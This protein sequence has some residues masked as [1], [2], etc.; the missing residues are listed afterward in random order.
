MGTLL[1]CP[2]CTLSRCALPHL[3]HAATHA[4]HATAHASSHGVHGRGRRVWL[5]CIHHRR[6][7]GGHEGSHGGRIHQRRAHHLCRVHHTIRHQ[8]RILVREGVEA[9]RPLRVLQH[10]AGDHLTC[11]AS[12][13][14]DGD[15][16]LAQSTLDELDAH[17]LV[18]VVRAG[19]Q[20]IQ[21]LRGTQERGS[22]TRHD[23]LLH[24]SAG[25]VQCVRDAV[26]LLAD[27]HLR[28]AT[29]LD[30]SDTAR[31]LGE[32]LAQ[33]L[34]LVLARRLLHLRAD[35][36]AALLDGVLAAC[37]VQHQGI[38]LG[39]GD[40]A[41][42]A[43]VVQCR[44]LQLHPH[45]LGDHHATRQLGDVLQV[46]LAV[47]TEAGGLDGAHLDLCPQAV[48][49]Q[50]GQ[51]LALNVLC[52]D[53]QRLVLADGGFQDVDDGL[54][55]RHL[56]L[57]QQDVR[58]LELHL[59]C[60]GVGDEVRRDEA[61]VEAHAFHDLQLVLQRPAVLHGDHALLA[62][63]LH[64]L[65]DEAANV[66]V[67]VCG[68]GGHLGDLFRGGDGGGFGGQ[69]VHHVG[70]GSIHAAL[71]VHGVHARS[72]G[73]DALAV[74]GTAQHGGRGGA[75]TC[76]IVGVARHLADQLGAHVHHAILELNVLGHSH[77]ILG[78]LGGTKALV[79]QG[80]APL[81][82]KGD[83]DGIRKLV[84]TSKQCGA[85]LCTEIN[86]LASGHATAADNSCGLHVK[87]E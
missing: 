85:G 62:H 2:M 74:D 34:L 24:G 1:L 86:V 38:L 41:S 14:G 56:L 77:T 87:A 69:E 82:S 4:A 83:L 54:H 27:L 22:A 64:A 48:D 36:V 12:V 55:G 32:A 61:T 46:G 76:S 68:D 19:N 52:D 58:V 81:G 5:R 8:V 47:V 10:L 84:D 39:D 15:G 7:C 3:E 66:R 29:N 11:Q 44:G 71:Q 35:H 65:G 28:G 23:A 6:F 18:L 45:L 72:D 17:A 75:V 33:L 16:R 37:A 20:V 59:L 26:L 79:Q 67:V 50:A 70:H 80:V 40:L 53:E 78:D 9:V 49:D 63:L 21:R 42:R 73:L 31:E 13:G 30:H 25:R 51:G 43:Q 60:G 57:H